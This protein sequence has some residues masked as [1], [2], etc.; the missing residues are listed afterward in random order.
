MSQ[1]KLEEQEQELEQSVRLC[2]HSTERQGVAK[3]FSGCFLIGQVENCP[4]FW[5]K[6]FFISFLFVFF[7][8]SVGPAFPI[9]S[10]YC[11]LGYLFLIFHFENKSLIKAELGKVKSRFAYRNRHK[12]MCDCTCCGVFRAFPVSVRVMPTCLETDIFSFVSQLISEMQ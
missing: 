8:A 7:F 11:T 3:E 1:L 2:P 5:V 10:L 6:H 4:G 9:C 12:W